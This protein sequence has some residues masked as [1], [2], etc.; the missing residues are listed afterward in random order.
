MGLAEK[1]AQF[2]TDLDLEQI[3]APVVEKARACVLN[4]YGIALGSHTTP[5]FSVA[6]RA[7]LAMDG[8]RA[9]GNAIE[10]RALAA[11][12][13]EIYGEVA[14]EDNDDCFDYLYQGQDKAAETVTLLQ[15]QYVDGTTDPANDALVTLHFNT[16]TA[17]ALGWY[18]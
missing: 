3:P 10:G 5:F 11:L 16:E 6:E 14:L 18:W 4:G 2:V 7:V 8:E 12:K 13:Q 17:E 9:D 15:R 1:F